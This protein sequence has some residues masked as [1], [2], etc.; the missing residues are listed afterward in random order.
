MRQ[1][2]DVKVFLAPPEELRKIWKIKR[3]TSKRGYTPDQV[4]AELDK[5]ETDSAAF[6]RPQR[7]FADIV[8]QFYPPK[9]FSAND[10]GGNLNVRLILRPTIRH[11]DL[12]YLFEDRSS[13]EAGIRMSLGRDSGKPVDILE[14]EGNVSAEHACKLEEV[15]WQHLPEQHPLSA[16]QFGNY[17]DQNETYHSDPLA[18]TQMLLAYHLLR[19]YAG[20]MNLNF[21]PPVSALSRLHTV[22]PQR[23]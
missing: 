5:R 2:Y 1:F 19:D 9:Q 23:R 14:I 12:S 7:E 20:E 21:A 17:I 18:I 16:N 11:P 15:I 6:I 3:D 8:V 10:V 22:A 13:A 4:L